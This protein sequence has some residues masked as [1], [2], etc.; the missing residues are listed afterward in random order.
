MDETNLYQGRIQK[1]GLGG[2][3]NHIWDGGRKKVALPLSY[4]S[5]SQ[6]TDFPLLSQ[7]PHPFI[8]NGGGGIN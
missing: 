7:S 5:R 2:G 3:A 8:L 4:K 6:I 1:S